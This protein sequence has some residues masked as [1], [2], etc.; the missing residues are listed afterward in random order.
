MPSLPSSADDLVD[1]RAHGL[2]RGREDSRSCGSHRATAPASHARAIASS[3]M[4][5]TSSPRSTKSVCGYSLNRTMTSANA[6]LRLGQVAMRIE[7]DADHA[8]RADQRAHALEQVALAVVIAERDHGAVQSEHDA[9]ER[10]GGLDLARGSCRASA[11]RPRVVAG[12]PGCAAKQEPSISVK[13]PRLGALARGPERAGLVSRF[14]RVRCRAGNA[15]SRRRPGT[16]SA[17]ARTCWPR[18]RARQHKMRIEGLSELPS[19]MRHAIA[20]GA[21]GSGPAAAGRLLRSG[22]RAR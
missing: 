17:A 2:D 16:R 8:V 7:L 19:Q 12:P 10:Q 3:T 4:V 6:H 21:E 15:A 5:T 1:E 20:T 13:L 9:V 22:K 14:G 11:H 18:G